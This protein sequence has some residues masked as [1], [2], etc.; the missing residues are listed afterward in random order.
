MADCGQVTS[1]S[2]NSV[3]IHPSDFVDLNIYGK[4]DIPMNSS[5]TNASVRY[6]TVHSCLSMLVSETLTDASLN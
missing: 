1:V 5:V 6:G 2:Q 3:C 4:R